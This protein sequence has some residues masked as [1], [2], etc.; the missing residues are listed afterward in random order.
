MRAFLSKVRRKAVQVL[1]PV[2]ARFAVLHKVRHKLAYWKAEAVRD[3][4]EKWYSP[5]NLRAMQ[6]LSNRRFLLQPGMAQAKRADGDWPEIDVS[7]V[8]YNSERW[9]GQFVGS[10]QAQRYPLWRIH[11]RFVD[12]GSQD[13]TVDQ[14]RSWMQEAETQFASVSL[15][16]QEN[17]GF[18]AGHDRA[19]REG[20]SDYCLVTNLDLEFSPDA[21]IEVVSAA[22]RD[23]AGEVASWELR[24]VP[25][26]HPKYY[27]PVT[28][29]TNWSS[30]ACI[31]L[32]R[33]AY[34]K[35]T[36][37]EPR[38]FMYAE[39][40]ELSYR[41]RSYG[42]ALKYVPRA[43]V[44]HYTYQS[45]GEVKPMQFTGS[46]IGNVYL[47]VR[48]GSKADRMAGLAL[49]SSL[50]MMPALF[51]GARKAL[52]QN[53]GKLMGNWRHF[54]RGKGDARASFPFRAM[55]YEFRRDG[56]FWEVEP[57]SPSQA[58]LV[59]IVT[60]TYRGRGMFLRQAM[61]SVFN[62]AYPNI[63]LIVVED[64]GDTQKAVVDAMSA[65]A[66]PGFQ[67]RFLPQ[68][69][70]GRSAAG[71]AGLAAATGQ[72]LMFLDDDDLLFADHVE[73][74]VTALRRRPE[75]SAAYALAVEV[76]TDLDKENDRY[77]ET[78]FNTPHVFFQEWD[79][80][81]MT[82]HNF[83]PIQAILFKRELY[84]QRGGFDVE[85]DQLEDW[86]LWL[87]YGHGQQ[88]TYVAK[89]TSLF[90]SPADFQ[91]RSARALLLHEAYNQAKD[92]A[93]EAVGHYSQDA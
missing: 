12:H 55:D 83:I 38:L 76:H 56:A 6:D 17:L 31:L 46:T 19:I 52:L 2:Y 79:Y 64:G 86:N 72:Y 60:R 26:E 5:D 89:T 49:Y 91:T 70:L 32:R 54:S 66:P 22:L 81:V 62:Q 57:V 47:R 78:E 4:K 93:A 40:V 88:F 53:A 82:D 23:Q 34:E 63:E 27:D 65:H 73:T 74:L 24:Q 10:L 1:R 9:I 42:Y 39:D 84:E 71:N 14:I 13:G 43:V 44:H 67:V 80:E 16:E 30:H 33:S 68:P 69:K 45:A 48:Y 58:P 77:V 37:Y 3:I 29:E 87:R 92:K 90:R 11:L 7:V 8:S 25:F 21:L 41:F 51:P 50:F 85:L 59:S 35:V 28:L 36:G 20:K 18:G 75:A 15:I 61:Q